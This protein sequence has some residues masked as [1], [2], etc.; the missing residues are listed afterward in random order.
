MSDN[1]RPLVVDFDS[2]SVAE[3]PVGDVLDEGT[4]DEENPTRRLLR[5]LLTYLTEM[6]FELPDDLMNEVQ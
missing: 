1:K 4:V 3:L 6:G 2:G 5:T